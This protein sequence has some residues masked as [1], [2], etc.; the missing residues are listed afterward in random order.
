[1]RLRTNRCAL[2]SRK[3][4]F[5]CAF[6][7]LTRKTWNVDFSPLSCSLQKNKGAL[8]EILE[9][10]RAQRLVGKRVLVMVTLFVIL[11]AHFLHKTEK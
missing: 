8:L 3:F 7:F 4:I 10:L 5:F 1:M 11:L 2:S 9:L 6:N